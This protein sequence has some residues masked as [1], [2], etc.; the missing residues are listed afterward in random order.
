MGS[1]EGSREKEEEEEEEKVDTGL[2]S[3]RQGALPLPP[4]QTMCFLHPFPLS[5]SF[6]HV[7][8]TA[9]ERLS[10]RSPFCDVLSH[11]KHRTYHS[12][13]GG[14]ISSIISLCFQK[15]THSLSDFFVWRGGGGHLT[16]CFSR[17]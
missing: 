4:V 12:D 10:S 5:L 17:L 11:P 13:G 3:R 1:E 16:A 8:P 6:R 15:R 7:S 2:R 14:G 9:V